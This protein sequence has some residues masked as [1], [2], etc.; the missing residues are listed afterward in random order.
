MYSN[1]CYSIHT[2]TGW[3]AGN[4][5]SFLVHTYPD[6]AYLASPVHPVSALAEV[7]GTI[8]LSSPRSKQTWRERERGGGR[9]EERVGER[10]RK[11]GEREEGRREE[12][13]R[14]EGRREEGGREEGREDGGREE[15]R[16]GGGREERREQE[17]QGI[18]WV[19]E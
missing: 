14:E 16:K 12:G 7:W 1:T 6:Q 10:G 2:D 17:K 3:C 11:G 4:V 19:G 8:T 5:T 9:R 15:G 18:E 13:R